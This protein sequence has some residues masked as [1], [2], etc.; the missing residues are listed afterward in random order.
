[1]GAVVYH[2][3]R[4]DFKIWSSVLSSGI[5]NKFS[6]WAQILKI[7]R[8]YCLN[9]GRPLKKLTDG[10]SLAS[11][12]FLLHATELGWGKIFHIQANTRWHPERGSQNSGDA[13]LLASSVTFLL[14]HSFV[15]FL[16]CP[17]KWS[18]LKLEDF[19]NQVSSSKLVSFTWKLCQDTWTHVILLFLT[20]S[21]ESRLK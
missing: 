19:I 13:K 1:M 11:V 14:S 15:C 5:L 4:G 12:L 16:S 3:L 7:F 9:R 10:N 6:Y 18:I 17:S 21:R 20:R 2:I 8:F